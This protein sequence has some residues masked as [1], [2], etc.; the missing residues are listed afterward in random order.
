VHYREYAKSPKRTIR[1]I[2]RAG[3]K[4]F[5][6]FAVTSVGLRAGDRAHIFVAALGASTYT[7]ACATVRET[8]ADWLGTT[9]KALTIFGGVTRLIV[10]DNPKVMIAHAPSARWTMIASE[11]SNKNAICL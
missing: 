5:I 6:D 7:F 9:A 10:P 2:L 4:L 3:E 11:F 1:Q 8:M